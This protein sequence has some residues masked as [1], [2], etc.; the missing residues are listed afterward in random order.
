MGASTEAMLREG[1]DQGMKQEKGEW[2]QISSEIRISIITFLYKLE[3]TDMVLDLRNQ[4]LTIVTY[5]QIVFAQG[6]CCWGYILKIQVYFENWQF[7]WMTDIN[8]ITEQV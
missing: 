3:I 1:V 2:I 7:I 8:V 4:L 6:Q 5:F